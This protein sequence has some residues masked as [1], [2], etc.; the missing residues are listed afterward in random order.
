MTAR[1][2]ARR[3]LLVAGALLSVSAL[4][5]LSPGCYAT[6]S[7]TA[8]P[9]AAFYFPV[10]LAVSFGGNVLYAVN[11]DFDL[12][13]NGGTLQSY[14][15]FHIRHDAAELIN[16]N[17]TAPASVAAEQALEKQVNQDIRF[18]DPWRSGCTSPSL[19]QVPPT[20]T[21]GSRVPL[22]QACAPPVEAEPYVQKSVTIGAFATDLQLSRDGSRLFAPVRGDGTLTWADVV[23][24]SPES[25]PAADVSPPTNIAADGAAAWVPVPRSSLS[26]GPKDPADL[27]CGAGTDLRC[28]GAHH[29]GAI[30]DGRDSRG[31]T[32][33]G[34]PFAMAQTQ[35]GT[36]IAITH[37]TGTETSLLLSELP[38]AL[39]GAVG[40]GGET[41]AGAGGE[42][43]GDTDAA[44]LG[45]KGTP[46]GS[47]E[48]GSEAEPAAEADA[49]VD[50][51]AGPPA[52]D[53]RAISPDPSM[54]FVLEGVPSG[55][56]GIVAVPHDPEGPVPPCELVGLQ[57]PC[58]RPA[59]LQTSHS[60]AEIDLLRYYSDDGSGVV[61]PRPFLVR[62]AAYTL[63]ANIGGTDSRDIVIDS[64]PRQACKKRSPADAADC[65]KIPARVFFA[66]RT[67]PALV[68]GEIGE[69]STTAET[70]YDPD[71]LVI[72]GNMPISNGGSRVYLAPI[73]D[74]TGHYALRV[75][76]VCFDAAQIFVYDPEA[77][78]VENVIN[79]G[80]GPFAMAFDPFDMK[81]VAEQAPVSPDTRQNPSLNLKRYRFA[82]VASFTQSFVQAIDLDD[83]LP[84][85]MSNVTFERVVFTLGQPTNPKGS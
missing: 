67:P 75:F 27:Y 46:D 1:G 78:L 55:G 47:S 23:P 58:V 66:S 24:D 59:F 41:D 53:L 40:I 7:G 82:Y 42:T 45:A 31:V 64:T 65:A 19:V 48:A 85:A 84:A 15:L 68:I 81:D 22:G 13:W 57:A 16:A 80:P 39:S 4:A 34:E 52:V 83:S 77:G 32:L 11:S 10:G 36:A 73:V 20:E 17:F 6:A 12:Q 33:P 18:G 76:V 69:P 63:S 5:V 60:V 44:E 71:R 9:P 43:D 56:D 51:A 62:E 70:G 29:T 8:P 28:D 30:P 25:V 54:Q 3:P 50:G 2:S 74:R 72:T 37:Q 79:V 49:T 14:D 21:N 26:P 38:P 35:D 61:L